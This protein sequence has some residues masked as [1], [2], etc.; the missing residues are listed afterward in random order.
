MKY[1]KD[2]QTVGLFMCLE[3][4]IQNAV[5]PDPQK[6]ATLGVFWNPTN[7]IPHP[8][9]VSLKRPPSSIFYLNLIDEGNP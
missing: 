7:E 3:N 2:T 6:K 5:D 1:T 8:A 9:D 4:P